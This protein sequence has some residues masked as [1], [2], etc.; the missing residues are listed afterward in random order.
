[1]EVD[2]GASVSIMSQNTYHKLW[3]RRGLSTSA[4]TDVQV[5][6]E[7]QTTTLPL[8]VVKGDGP[9]LLVRNWLGKLKLNWGK[10]H[11]IHDKSWVAGYAKQV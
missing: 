8:V 3:P 4:I 6:Y 9:T 2:T 1:M 11:Y 10:I 7:G 5:V